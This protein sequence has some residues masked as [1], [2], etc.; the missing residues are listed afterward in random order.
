MVVHRFVLVPKVVLPVKVAVAWLAVS[1]RVLC[2]VLSLLRFLEVELVGYFVGL[3][4]GRLRWL[5]RHSL[6][7]PSDS[8]NGDRGRDLSI[9]LHPS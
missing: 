5:Q 2:P 7:R 1:L 8:L 6:V 4:Y 3:G 9:R